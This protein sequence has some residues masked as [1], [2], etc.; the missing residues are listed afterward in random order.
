[1]NNTVAEGGTMSHFGSRSPVNI[2]EL[3]GVKLFRGIK[4][5]PSREKGPRHKRHPRM[6]RCRV[7]SYA[8]CPRHM[9]NTEALCISMYLRAVGEKRR[10]CRGSSA[11]SI[12]TIVNRDNC[13]K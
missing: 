3:L 9:I 6:Y 7:K 4:F 5:I 1:L 13:G 8:S 2:R 11:V 10:W 12:S